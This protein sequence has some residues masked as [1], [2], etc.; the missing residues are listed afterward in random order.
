MTEVWAA[1]DTKFAQ[2]QDLINAVDEEL[3]KLLNLNCTV[4]EYIVKL[5]NHLPNLEAVDGLDHLQSPDS[6]S[7]M[8]S[9]FDD[10]TLQDWDCFRSKATGSTYSRLLVSLSIITMC[11]NYQ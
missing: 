11:A 7:L 1:L 9:R 5:R 2:E 8:I 3:S 10:R 4:A 6:V